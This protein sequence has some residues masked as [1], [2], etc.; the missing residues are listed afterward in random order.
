MRTYTVE[1]DDRAF[2]IEVSETGADTFEVSVDGATYSATLT[3]DRDVPGVAIAPG[4]AGPGGPP[5]PRDGARQTDKRG[6]ERD[7]VPEAASSGPP[8]TPRPTAG[9]IAA[10]MPGVVLE[11]L[12]AAGA[13]VRRGD[14]L[15]VLEAMK[16]RNTIRAPR[17]A[18]V[19]AVVVGPGDGIAAG[20]AL[21]RLDPPP[22]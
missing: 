1:I 18:I 22:G 17:A 13:V 21:V 20:Q 11:L 12:V 6:P 15:L 14:P 10:P 5:P 3:G 2:T 8:V 9:V 4:I 16:M 7:V 19:A